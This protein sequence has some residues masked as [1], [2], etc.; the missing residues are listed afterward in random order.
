M[1]AAV[2]SGSAATFRPTCFIV[3]IARAPPNAAPRETSSATFSFGAHWARPP[4]AEK[5]SRISV[6]GVPG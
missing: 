3:T 6:D 4:R 2:K 5:A 1:Y